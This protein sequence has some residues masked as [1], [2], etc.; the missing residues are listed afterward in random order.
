MR[1]CP[2]CFARAKVRSGKIDD[3]KAM[4]GWTAAVGGCSTSSASSPSRTSPSTFRACPGSGARPL[5]TSPAGLERAVRFLE[6]QS[7]GQTLAAL[8]AVKAGRTVDLGALAATWQAIPRYR[9][10][11]RTWA[12]V[13]RDEPAIGAP[14]VE[15]LPVDS[16][17]RPAILALA[18]VLPDLPA[19]LAQRVARHAREYA[20]MMNRR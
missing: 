20:A 10:V 5:E 19:A 6:A 3:H 8:Q 4:S 9:A 12:P 1:T 13:D 15:V 2:F 16:A 7:Q 17:G 18:D 14:A 11:L